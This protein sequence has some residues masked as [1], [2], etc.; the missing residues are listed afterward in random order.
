MAGFIAGAG[1][2]YQMFASEQ[3]AQQ[4]RSTARANVK[5]INAENAETARRLKLEQDKTVS[6]ARA[7]AGASGIGFEGT[8]DTYISEMQKN[9][10]LERDWLKTSGI[11]QSGRE[12]RRGRYQA[13]TIRT[14]AWGSLA[15]SAGSIYGSEFGVK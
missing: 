9:F 10:K 5:D 8:V 2:L 7:K 1:A 14:N 3:E 15:A 13:E 11:R 6:L 4:A 12:K